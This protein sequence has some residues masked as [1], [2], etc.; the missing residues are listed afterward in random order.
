MPRPPHWHQRSQRKYSWVVQMTA[1]LPLKTAAIND[2]G[3]AHVDQTYLGHE[4]GEQLKRLS[5]MCLPKNFILTWRAV[6]R[7][8]QPRPAACDYTFWSIYLAAVFWCA[9][10]LRPG[11]GFPLLTK[12]PI[13]RQIAPGLHCRWP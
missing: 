4:S 10:L 13:L 11:T 1:L 6:P 3:L 12:F 2:G 7:M 9:R 8:S 5:L